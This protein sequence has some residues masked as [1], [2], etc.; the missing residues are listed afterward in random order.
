[1]YNHS[2]FGLWGEKQ[3]QKHLKKNGLKI[4]ETNYETKFGEIDV[5]CLQTKAAAKKQAKKF[6][7]AIEKAHGKDR[8]DLHKKLTQ[9]QFEK[10]DNVLVFVEVK[11]RSK[12]SANAVEPN[13]AVDT[14]KQSKYAGVAKAFAAANEKFAQMPWRFDIVE[15]VEENGKAQLNHIECA[16]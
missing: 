9:K 6:E 3:A 15:V 7:K 14:K 16:F 10:A 8:F 11:S 13:E 2:E 4:L 5:I 12:A 1:M